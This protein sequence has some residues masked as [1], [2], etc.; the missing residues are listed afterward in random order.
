M[1]QNNWFSA[2]PLEFARDYNDYNVLI[3]SE[4]QL[5]WHDFG[6]NKKTSG[7]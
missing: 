5:Q 6:E 7:E 2:M 1:D 3:R 4:N